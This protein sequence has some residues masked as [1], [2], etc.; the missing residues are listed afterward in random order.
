MNIRELL[1]SEAS[2]LNVLYAEDELETQKKVSQ[3]FELFFKDVCCA[4]N[5]EVALEKYKSGVY[6]LL[7]T[8]LTMPKMDGI[9]LIK[10]VKKI[11]PHQRVIVITAHNNNENLLD[12]IDLQV[13]GFL[14]KPIGMDKL[15]TLLYK[16]VHEIYIEK[17]SNACL[18]GMEKNGHLGLSILK[19]RLMEAPHSV[20]SAIFIDNIVSLSETFGKELAEYICNESQK[21]LLS[22]LGQNCSLYKWS[23][24]LFVSYSEERERDLVA[25][26][27][28]LFIKDHGEINIRFKEISFP[29]K[30]ESIIISG[31]GLEVINRL[32]RIK[33]GLY[34]NN[35]DI[36]LL[37]ELHDKHIKTQKDALYWLNKTVVAIE[38]NLLIPFYQP[39]FSIQTK[40]LIGY[41]VLARLETDGE[42]IEP[43]FFVEL[44]EKAGISKEIS[45]VIYR[46]AFENFSS[47]EYNLHLNISVEELRNESLI[48]QLLLMN[49]QFDI[50]PERVVF[51]INYQA[52]YV[53]EK[54]IVA[55]MHNLKDA[56]FKILIENFGESQMD[57]QALKMLMPHIIKI[58]RQFLLSAFEDSSTKKILKAFL[59]FL[60]SI[61]IE[62]AAVGVENEALYHLVEELE[63][64]YA[65]GYYLAKPSIKVDK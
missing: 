26:E 14:L 61:G 12:T 60:R 15:I 27:M 10:E 49:K 56:G 2:Q 7:I 23:K 32:N 46:K 50:Q 51:E 45:E 65:Q 63:F 17:K 54:T 1:K 22:Q 40:A 25:E 39:I 30:F 5:G 34:A 58:D 35:G 18:L 33:E 20:V 9:S 43:R 11:T 52:A 8:D 28:A 59:Y 62:S 37:S 6:D 24:G 29:I 16:V 47:R 31:E 41:E 53:K 38:N 44:S 42:Y 13:D 4:E 19:S 3:I 57:M 36:K 21:F 64:D 48:N 55:T